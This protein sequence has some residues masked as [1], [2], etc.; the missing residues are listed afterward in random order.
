MEE[1]V[2]QLL[3]LLAD[4]ETLNTNQI[5]VM[6]YTQLNNQAGG[7]MSIGLL[8]VGLIGVLLIMGLHQMENNMP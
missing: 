5:I 3:V 7:A 8:M 2:G 6:L 4:G 1:L